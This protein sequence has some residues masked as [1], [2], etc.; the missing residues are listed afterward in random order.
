VTR[1]EFPATGGF[2]AGIHIARDFHISVTSA[3]EQD[4]PCDLR[5]VFGTQT[6]LTNAT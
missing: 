1:E 5:G 4:F 6:N 2:S 3:G